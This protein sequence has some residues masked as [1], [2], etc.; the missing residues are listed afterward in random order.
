MSNNV[1][2]LMNFVIVSLTSLMYNLI[3]IKHD[4]KNFY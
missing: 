1:I 4:Q 2:F 3:T